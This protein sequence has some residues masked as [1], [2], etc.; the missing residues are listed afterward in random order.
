MVCWKVRLCDYCPP[1]GKVEAEEC[2]LKLYAVEEWAVRSC[3]CV[4]VCVRVCARSYLRVHR[5]GA[6]GRC[7]A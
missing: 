6:S 4:R 7:A 1:R 3:L 2:A 5:V